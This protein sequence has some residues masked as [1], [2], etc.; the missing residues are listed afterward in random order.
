M[1]NAL[2]N[3][4]RGNLGCREILSEYWHS[5]YSAGSGSRFDPACEDNGMKAVRWQGSSIGTPI[6]AA[7]RGLESSA[8]GMNPI[9]KCGIRRPKS[10]RLLQEARSGFD[11]ERHGRIQYLSAA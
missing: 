8:P 11:G 7:G 3:I 5:V 6:A 4:L 1:G 9:A 10:I 2:V